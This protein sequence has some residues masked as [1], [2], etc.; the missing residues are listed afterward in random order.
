MAAAD[1]STSEADRLLQLALE[2]CFATF[3]TS[4]SGRLT[5]E[6]LWDALH[7]LGLRPTHDEVAWMVSEYA[8]SDDG[9]LSEN[10]YIQMMHQYID[11]GN[12]PRLQYTGNSW[13]P[14]N[15]LSLDFDF[16]PWGKKQTEFKAGQ[17]DIN[18]NE[19]LGGLSAMI[20]RHSLSFENEKTRWL[21]M[22]GNPAPAWKLNAYF[23]KH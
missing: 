14:M 16:L 20:S 18:S 6:E 3:D 5:L 4:K 7:S 9:S 21:H 2:K 11:A 10:E 12:H 17:I 8:T 19:G 1:S 15:V 22:E 23:A 13:C